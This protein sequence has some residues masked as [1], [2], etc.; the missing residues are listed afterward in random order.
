MERHSA[1]AS[2]GQVEQSE[3]K[4]AALKYA[5]EGWHVMPCIPN[6]KAPLGALVPNGYKDATDDPEK[7]KAWWTAQ[8]DANIGLVPVMSGRV[9]VDADTYK[10]GCAFPTLVALHGFPETLMQRSARGGTHYV[11]S[12]AEGAKYPGTLGEAT[13]VKFKGYFLAAPSVVD[14]KSYKWLNSAPI[15]AAPEWMARPQ[16]SAAEVLGNPQANDG[17]TLAEVEEALRHIPADC[18]YGDWL[19]ILQALHHGFGADALTLADE[20]SMTAPHR[21]Q[22]S[23]VDQKFASFRASGDG[24]QVTL[25]TLFR[26]AEAGGANLAELKHK[27]LANRWFAVVDPETIN[28][29]VVEDDGASGMS[30]AA[31][32]FLTAEAAA[33]SA[34]P[35]H[36][37]D[38]RAMIG[39]SFKAWAPIDP[40]KIPAPGFVYSDFYARGYMS[41]TG[42]APKVGKSAL[43]HAESVDMA[44]GRGFLTGRPQAPLKVVYFN[45]EDDQDV[46]NARTIA[47]L[48]A[49]GIDQSE[50]EG[51]LFVV[52]GVA[53]GGFYLSS[54]PDPQINEPLFDDLED[55]IVS[56]GIDV[57]ILDPLQ[58]MTLSPETNE[59]YRALAQRLRRLLAATK[60][61][62]GVV[63]HFRKGAAG[64]Q[65]TVD[66]LRGGS[67]LRGAARFNRAI[68]PMTPDEAA[69]AGVAD[70]RYFLRIADVEGNLAPP[71][72]EV[73][74]WFEKT[75]VRLPNGQSV[76]AVKPWEWP[77][78]MEGFA[79]CEA[80]ILA[81][82]NTGL[83]N[84]ERY[85]R[86]KKAQES[87]RWVV[88]LILSMTAKAG[89][90]K[91]EAQAAAIV[92]KWL[93]DG[94]V[95]D[96]DY[97]SPTDRN[98][99]KGL[100]VTNRPA[101]DIFE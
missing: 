20:W 31:R 14:G 67:A 54:G 17:T 66:E 22:E 55:F 91:T 84:G 45:A 68:A 59:V 39:K 9:V 72:A 92:Q 49:H 100:Y 101:G 94:T 61:A 10:A 6:D 76:I 89:I 16:R 63:H 83:V 97:K 79:E 13:D 42:A 5:A 58:D 30:E 78:A 62:L 46:L 64:A 3:M 4:R 52:S 93:K 81:A 48:A 96:R 65:V 74:R 99:R 11:L 82:V 12:A 38:Y 36:Q 44:T 18:S 56:E 73:N 88:D 41:V 69:K 8:P 43:A 60:V 33:G 35:A 28:Q 70:H 23:L 15:A 71:S 26:R 27:Y 98:R 21:Y 2:V 51:R 90:S 75:S 86:G 85:A 29:L 77:D 25:G 32:F 53:L 34:Q 37:I 80:A 95:E 1:K 7:I 19:E 57:L 87:G 47:I 40:A 24:P 50:I